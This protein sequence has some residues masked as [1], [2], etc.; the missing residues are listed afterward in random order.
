MYTVMRQL[1]DWEKGI[2]Y[3]IRTFRCSCECMCMCVYVYKL[4]MPRLVVR[5]IANVFYTS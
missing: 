2:M 1:V 4:P 5:M 3:T